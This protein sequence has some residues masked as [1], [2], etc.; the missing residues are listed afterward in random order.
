MKL[1]YSYNHIINNLMSNKNDTFDNIKTTLPVAVAPEANVDIEAQRITTNG[2][3]QVL[4]CCCDAQSCCLISCATITV[5]I[6]IVPFIVCDLFFAYNNISCQHDLNP[7][8]FSLSTWLAVSGWS[9]LG[10]L[11]LL[12]LLMICLS[13]ETKGSISVMIVQYLYSVFSFAWLIVGC[14][15]FWRYLDPSGNCDRDVSNYMWAR[16]IIGLVGV[17]ISSKTNSKSDK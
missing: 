3:R 17:F 10:F 15:M 5:L 11:G 12:C 8:G 7:I 14:V 4:R 1:N 2:P 9:L 13:C 16:L 6:L